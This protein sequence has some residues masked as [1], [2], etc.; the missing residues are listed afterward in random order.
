VLSASHDL[1]DGI[2]IEYGRRQ[3]NIELLF[4][5]V[6]IFMNRKIRTFVIGTVLLAIVVLGAFVRFGLTSAGVSRT[7]ESTCSAEGVKHG[8]LA[9]LPG[10]DLSRAD[11][12]H[13][14]LGLS[15]AAND[16]STLLEWRVLVERDSWVDW[17]FLSVF[18]IFIAWIVVGGALLIV[19]AVTRLQR[20][21]AASDRN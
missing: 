7:A 14:P 21:R 15:C 11:V 4:K 8:P 9:H 20:E 6:R 16:G 5:L 1:V 12:T 18:V 10:L 19:S 13:F 2:C 17:F 3:S